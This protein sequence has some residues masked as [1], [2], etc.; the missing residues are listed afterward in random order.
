[1]NEGKAWNGPLSLLELVTLLL[2][3]FLQLLQLEANEVVDAQLP[4]AKAPQIHLLALGA[5]RLVDFVD[6]AS[7]ALV[8]CRSR[9]RIT[10]LKVSLAILPETQ[11]KG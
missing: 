1:M 9:T 3:F 11:R 10:I 4:G 6:G 2:H 8:T 7:A 5:L